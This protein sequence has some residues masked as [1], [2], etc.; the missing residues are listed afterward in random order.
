M[1]IV[2]AIASLLGDALLVSDDSGEADAASACIEPRITWK[3]LPWACWTV[4][5]THTIKNTATPT[6]PWHNKK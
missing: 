1:A 4:G 5:A 3:D 2:V 6:S